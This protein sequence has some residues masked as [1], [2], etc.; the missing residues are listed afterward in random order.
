MADLGLRAD[1]ALGQRRL[2][3]QESPGDLVGGQASERPQGEGDLRF[4]IEG[5]VAAGEDEAET[6]VR[7]FDDLRVRHFEIGGRG[8]E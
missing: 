3:N 1:E 5:R 6:V 8:R 4:R 7:Q 2:G